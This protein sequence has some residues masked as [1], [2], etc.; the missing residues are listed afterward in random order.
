MP[1]LVPG[2]LCQ[3]LE[4]RLLSADVGTT[5]C[6]IPSAFPHTP[7]GKAKPYEK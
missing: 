1:P 5:Q 6:G 4:E 3:L 7:D 2:P